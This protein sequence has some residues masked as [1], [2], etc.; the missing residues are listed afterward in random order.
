MKTNILPKLSIAAIAAITLVGNSASSA[1]LVYEGFQY[2]TAA[3]LTR[4]DNDSLQGQAD[5]SGGDIDATNLGGTWNDVQNST[6][7]E[8]YLANGSLAFGDLPSLGNHVRSD[9]NANSDIFTRSITTSLSGS[10]EL[11]FSFVANKL[12]NNFSAA[13]GGL[14]I[15]NQVVNNS[16]VLSDNGT[17]GL[18]GFG[19][20]PTTAGDNWTAYAWNGSG[21]TVGDAVLGVA[22][23]G[24]ETNLL[25]GKISYNTGAGGTDEYAIYQYVLN[26]G[27]VTGGS[28]NQ[29]GS[30]I[31]IDVTE[32]D[33]DTL[34]L[35]RQV[36]TAYDEIR[37]GESLDDVI[38]VVPEPSTTALLGLG[39]LALIL[40]R[41]K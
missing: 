19:I 30:T 28:L 8:L 22:T 29:I 4:T 5:G 10:S 23:N 14:V 26:A 37:I 13:E 2:G 17:S 3:D 9:T 1:V 6:T 18:S 38:G 27:S 11:W 34:S 40:R 15:G 33:L 12:Q 21:Q 35:T 24:T 16:R 41:R 25:V 7:G 32:G 39:G 20:A 36:N 31:E